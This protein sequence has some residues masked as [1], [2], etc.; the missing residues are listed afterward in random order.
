MLDEKGIPF[1]PHFFVD[2]SNASSEVVATT[3]AKV[4]D[5]VD[6]QYIVVAKSNK[7]GFLYYPACSFVPVSVVALAAQA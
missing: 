5:E 3:I 2:T 6:A 7:V 1:I 4:S